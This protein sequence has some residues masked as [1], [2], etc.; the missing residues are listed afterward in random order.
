MG[1]YSSVVEAG[2]HSEQDHIRPLSMAEW[3]DLPDDESGEWVD[4]WLVEEEVSTYL[5]ELLVGWF[6]AALRAWAVPL[7]GGVLGSEFKFVVSPVRGRKPDISVFLRSRRP[8]LEAP[9]ADFPPDIAV[10]IVSG[11]PRDVRRDRVEKLAEYA[12]FGVRHYWLV[13]PKARTLEILDLR[14]GAY[15]RVLAASHGRVAPPG[16]EGLFIDLDALWAEV[17][18]AQEPA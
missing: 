7:G 3:I 1:G 6:I 11:R 5:H 2:A 14:D 12:R 10:E 18:R 17:D 4:G 8:S 16:C 15:A 9:A 13:D